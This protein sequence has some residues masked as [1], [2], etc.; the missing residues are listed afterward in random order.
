MQ[1][2]IV[3]LL[4][5]LLAALSAESLAAQR[6]QQG[7]LVIQVQSS[8]GPVSQAEILAGEI[9]AVTNN[10]G[11]ATLQVP[12]GPVEITVQRFG[13]KPKT[14]SVEIVDET[15]TNLTVELESES[16]F[17]EEITVTATRTEQRIEDVP[18]RIEVLQQE[19]VE[20]KAL[21]T[22]GDIAMM[23]NETGGLRVQVTSP[24]LGA[25]NVRIQGLRG[26]YTQLLADG[27]PLYGG[28][29]GA[30][31][32]LQI[33]PLDLGQVEVIKGVS[34]ALYG[35]SALGGVVNLVSRRP[36][37]SEHEFLFNRTS[38]GGTDAVLWLA[39]PETTR[40]GITL[41]TGAH[42]QKSTDVDGDGW[43]DLSR[44]N[45]LT[46]RPRLTW[47]NG[48]GK[49]F[50]AT[51]GGM[52]EDR[53]GGTIGDRLAPDGKPFQEKL[54][55]GRVDG[56]V[57]GHLPLGS[58]IVSIRGSLMTQLHR[59]QFGPVVEHDRHQTW[60]VEGSISGV[61][62]KHTWV[63]GTALQ[64]DAY[65]GKDVSRFDY[66]Y[67]V[68]AIFV[69]DDYALNSKA[70][71][72]GSARLDAHSAYGTFVSPRIS[73]LLR[74]PRQFTAR[75]SSG[76]GVFAPT[77]FT[78]ETE[79]VGLSNLAPLKNLRAEHAWSTSGDIG[80]TASH[81]EI[82][83]VV[84]GSLI[85]RPI[86]VRP[87]AG[88]SVGIEIVNASG[89]TR[90]VGSEFLARLRVGNFGLTVNHTYVHASE[91]DV[92]DQ[93]R[94]LVPLTPKH[95]AGIV[96]TWEKESSGRV[97]IEVFY[98][99]RQRLENNPYR[100]TSVPYWIF[101]LL[102]ERR[103]GPARLFVNAENLGNVRQ[104]RYGPLLRKTRNF[105]GRWTVDAWAP[106]EGRV[107]N[108]GIRLGF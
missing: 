90:T 92:Q 97:G 13:F 17:K 10:R 98:T 35:S 1:R 64:S 48:K 79:A 18:L 6:S 101:G 83:G 26:R 31:S 80:W 24:S 55:T 51:L 58:R 93:R 72:S 38:R 100:A 39:E 62:G 86:G 87:L 74:L 9:S 46:F 8:S 40:L 19:E 47:E 91:L 77:P 57:V 59:H 23:L 12:S 54:R 34:S 63:A 11:Q 50:Y 16:V 3:L 89:T 78:E 94:D 22:P 20:E 43:A 42:S 66:T 44:Y 25:A 84:F 82:N 53:G 108:G 32:L 99:G 4:Q 41:L 14:I 85:R 49:S 28:Q 104:T 75:L 52:A 67:T 33:P 29:T 96:G 45:R 36:K 102:I 103:L 30:L 71:L 65:R 2:P 73:A 106:L 7:T 60:F 5:L 15:M 37:Q 68:P 56:G 76:T 105:D 70:T 88:E 21:M 27:L 69:Q 61:S 107:I 95:T 81:V